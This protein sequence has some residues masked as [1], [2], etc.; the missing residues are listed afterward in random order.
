MRLA[1]ADPPYLGRADRYYGN[2]R[3]YKAGKGGRPDYHPEAKLWDDPAAHDMLIRDLMSGF[4]GFAL[5]GNVE[6]LPIYTKAMGERMRQDGGGGRV[7]VWYRP[8]AVPS[9][10]R[11]QA[12]W[13]PCVFYIPEGRRGRAVGMAVSDVLM[14]PAPLSF[15]G[16]KPAAWTRWVLAMM[17]YDPATDEVHDLFAGSGAVAFAADGM[18]V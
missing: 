4:D 16:A 12:A 13:E 5:A 2:G 15:V 6:S 10:S 14:A 17:G 11:I 3:G 18:L 8:N 9:G 1:I 7:G